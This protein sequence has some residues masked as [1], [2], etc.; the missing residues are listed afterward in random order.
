MDNI[1]TR[2]AEVLINDQWI[3]IFP[4]E[5][6]AG[7]TFRMFESDGESVIGLNDANSWV[8][9]SDAFYMENGVI[10]VDIDM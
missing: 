4:I 2:T 6:K 9:L 7:M 8:A 10:A 5:I 3:S 1:N